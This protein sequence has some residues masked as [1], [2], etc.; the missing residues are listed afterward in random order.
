[1]YVS[2]SSYAALTAIVIVSASPELITNVFDVTLVSVSED[3]IRVKLY[4]LIRFLP[5]ISMPLSVL[6]TEY[7][8]DIV[9]SVYL[10]T[11]RVQ[12]YG[13]SGVVS[14]IDYNHVSVGIGGVSLDTLI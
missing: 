6:L 3:E 9:S 5:P 7:E 1:M 11:V 2:P 10:I 14:G 8:V 13:F 12:R 4:S